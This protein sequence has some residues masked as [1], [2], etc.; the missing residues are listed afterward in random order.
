MKPLF[1]TTLTL[2]AVCLLLPAV[3]SD[4]GLT[5]GHGAEPRKDRRSL[6]ESFD[7]LKSRD[8]FNSALRQRNLVERA[9][10]EGAA[11]VGS[12]KDTESRLV[13]RDTAVEASQNGSQYIWMLADTYAGETFYDNMTFFSTRDPTNG[14]VTYVD[15][16]RAFSQNYTYIRDDG[17]VIMQSDMSSW[18]PL[19]A[20]RESVRIET[21]KAYTGGLFILDLQ[22]APWGCA[23]WPAFWTTA[24]NAFWPRDGEIDILEGVHDNEHNQITWH[25]NEGCY[26]DDEG[27]FGSGELEHPNRT[28]RG[29]SCWGFIGCGITEWSRA[30]YGPYFEAQGGGILAMKWD[31]EMIAVWSFFRA[32]IPPDVTDGM[33]KPSTW[34]RPSAVLRNTK[35]NITQHFRD[36]VIIFDIT[37]CGDLAGNNYHTAPNC[38]GTCAER[39]MDPA[40]FVNASW[41]IN[42]LKVYQKSP[43]FATV[44][45]DAAP[46]APW[47]SML[48]TIGVV[49]CLSFW[50]L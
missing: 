29:I 27:D 37:F 35:C 28:E 9:G 41:E 45:S 26:L 3:L 24:A 46:L 5:G 11:R 17:V 42:S 22:R 50:I 19:G 21:Q 47:L 7:S 44:G 38:P 32:A 30:S 34:G 25:T 40:N 20:H 4:P 18:L 23:I 12:E 16:D 6:L 8:F 48:A 31:D 36:H 15:R 10:Y 33:P 13:T 43:I 49:T 39:M 1:G 2:W 14:M